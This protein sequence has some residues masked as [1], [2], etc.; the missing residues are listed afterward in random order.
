MVMDTLQYAIDLLD[1]FES[2]ES[3]LFELGMTHAKLGI[4]EEHYFVLGRALINTL[5]AGLGEDFDA[6]VK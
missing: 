2:L 3:T 1:D 5:K 4:L 6:D